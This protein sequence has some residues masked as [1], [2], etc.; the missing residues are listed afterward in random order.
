MPI[1]YAGYYSAGNT[2][3]SFVSY[4]CKNISTEK[5]CMHYVPT[6]PV[7]LAGTNSHNYGRVEVYYNGEWG[8]VCDD[9]WDTADATVVCRQL[10]FYSTVI[11]YRSTRYG[12][13]TGP[14][15]LSRLSC[16]GNESSLF[17]CGQL[18]VGTKNCSHSN[19]ASVQC[20]YYYDDD[21]T[22]RKSF[23]NSY[24]NTCIL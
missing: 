1:R 13:G 21:R 2:T 6:V 9:G 12:Q 14:I 23:V 4:H 19:D 5:Q 3:C 18:N 22:R 20:G 10:G 7:R 24:R 11:A 17:E 15:W 8:T 16:F